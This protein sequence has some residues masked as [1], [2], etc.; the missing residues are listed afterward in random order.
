MVGESKGGKDRGAGVV[1]VEEEERKG[2][3]VVVVVVMMS[4]EAW[5]Q[6][7]P[8][9]ASRH[10][11]SQQQLLLQLLTL[12]IIFLSLLHFPLEHT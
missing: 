12:A 11:Q 5:K 2:E 4:G 1:V 10:L 9:P 3:G 6:I 8:T 7:P